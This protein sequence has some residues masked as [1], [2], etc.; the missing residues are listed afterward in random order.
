MPTWLQY[1]SGALPATY[2]AQAMRAIMGRGKLQ[3]IPDQLSDFV[4]LRASRV[5]RHWSMH[6]HVC[7]VGLVHV[8][9][10]CVGWGFIHYEVWRGFT[11]SGAWFI[12]FLFLAGLAFSL[13]K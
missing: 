10:L 9:Y 11:I 3:D 2:P 1:I 12:V 4:V 8:L 6:V 5:I 13:R 7:D